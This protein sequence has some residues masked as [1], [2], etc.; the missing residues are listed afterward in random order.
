MVAP[1]ETRDSVEIEI[2][3]CRA[4]IV[5]LAKNGAPA[6]S[7][8]KTLQTEFLEAATI[9]IDRQSRKASNAS[10]GRRQPYAFD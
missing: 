9:I 2:E 6:Q 4:K 1:R 10:A 7:G 3:K 8:L 5:A